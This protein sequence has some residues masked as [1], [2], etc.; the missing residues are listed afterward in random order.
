M[1]K[2]KYDS[3]AL[4]AALRRAG[5]TSTYQLGPGVAAA[6][7][8]QLPPLSSQRTVVLPPTANPTLSNSLTSRQ[9]VRTARSSEPETQNPMP[10]SI[11]GILQTLGNIAGSVLG[12]GT[13]GTATGPTTTSTIGAV[14]SGVGALAGTLLPGSGPTATMAAR[15]ALPGRASG[16]SDVV[17][18]RTSGTTYGAPSGWSRKKI[19][20]LVRFVGP[21]AAASIVGIPLEAAAIIAVSTRTRSRGISARD[22]RVT[23]RVTRRVLGIA[24]DL[25][26]IRPPARRVGGR[27][28][29][30]I[31]N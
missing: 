8:A 4:L 2:R 31:C 12:G 21:A 22:L 20:A 1:A 9:E 6:A 24:R 13:A 30:Q 14:A 3:A 23:R 5:Y 18:E 16:V 25:A 10:I 19:K 26:A 28:I 27:S 15:S 7:V 29:R 17:L 11:G